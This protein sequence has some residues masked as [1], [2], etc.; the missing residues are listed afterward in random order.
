[1]FR[2]LASMSLIAAVG[3][4]AAASASAKGGPNVASICGATG[5]ITIRGEMTVRP[6]LAGQGVGPYPARAR[7]ECGARL[8]ARR[9]HAQAIPCPPNWRL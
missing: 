1:V 2:I 9:R 8:P 4:M 7:E 3:A 6:L 5:C